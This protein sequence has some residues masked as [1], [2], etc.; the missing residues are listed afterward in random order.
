[1]RTWGAPGLDPRVESEGSGGIHRFDGVVDEIQNDAE[2]GVAVGPHAGALGEIETGFHRDSLESD[3]RARDRGFEEG[4]HVDAFEAKFRR[5][6]DL[7]DRLVEAFDR[8]HP[9][10]DD[11]GV[12][13]DGRRVGVGIPAGALLQLLHREPDRRRVDSR[14][15]AR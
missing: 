7:G 10:F 15:R 4:K 14:F 2:E 12:A 9:F 3:G 1:M 5:R 11:R 13:D 6:A 8:L